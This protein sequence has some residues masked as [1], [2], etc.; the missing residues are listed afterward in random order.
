MGYRKGSF[1]R[2]L[3]KG[4]H[5]KRIKKYGGTRGGIRL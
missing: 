3:K 1:K 4:R 2:R 5:G